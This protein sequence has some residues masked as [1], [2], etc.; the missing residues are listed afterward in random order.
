MND[1]EDQVV[2]HAVHETSSAEH[3]HECWGR[4]E[5]SNRLPQMIVL[6]HVAVGEYG[7]DKWHDL[8]YEQRR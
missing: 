7:S 5:V 2:I 4:R 6:P 1:V 8:V 3:A